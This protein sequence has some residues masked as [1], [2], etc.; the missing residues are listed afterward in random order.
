[1]PVSH[2]IRTT[3]VAGLLFVVG[4]PT[5][6]C[7][8]EDSP[9]E[10]QERR[11]TLAM[12]QEVIV[13]TSTVR[14]ELRGTDRLEADRAR[15]DIEGE[16]G[17]EE[18]SEN[19]RTELE[20][21]GQVGDLYV[22][23]SAASDLWPLLEPGDDAH[24]DGHI[25]VVFEDALNT[26]NRGRIEDVRWHF[27]RELEPT[28]EVDADEQLF[29]NAGIEVRGEGVLRPEEGE[30]QA[31]IDNGEI[32][33]DGGDT[34]EL[35]GQTLPVEWIGERDRGVLRL[36]PA[37]VGVHPG[38][39][40]LDFHFQ[41]HFADDT[42][43][44]S[45]GEPAR[46]EATL[47]KTF[48]A[49]LSPTRAGR[50][51]LVDIQGRGFVPRSSEDNYG[52]LLRFEG[53]LT[54][55][56]PDA[57]PIEFEGNSAAERPPYR[58]VDE[59]HLR[60]DVWYRVEDRQLEGV[61]AQP[62]TFSGEIT[63]V[64]YDERGEVEGIPWEGEF[65]VL[66]TRQVVYLKYLP[67]FTVA[68]DKYGLVNVERDI[69][70]RIREVAE[71][72]YEGVNVDFVHEPPE[73]FADYATIELGGPDPTGHEAFGIDNTYHD[74]PKDTGNLHL[75]SY[76]GG[77]NPE[78]GEELNTPYGGVFI[79][80]F[81]RFSPTLYPDESYASEN[82]DEVF[83]P[84]MPDLGGEKVRATEWPDGERSDQ[85]EEAIRVFG[86]VVGNTV[87]HELGH[88]MGLTHFE[89]DWEEPG[90]RYHNLEA[91]GHIMDAGQER[92]F[93]QRAQL[94]GEG[95]EVF[96]ETNRAYLETILP[97]E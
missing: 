68:L 67:A 49:D 35:D 40:E 92:S 31:V 54:P 89:E 26:I 23:L 37:V 7:T 36:D 50:G 12:D 71:R 88:S 9:E 62:G 79:E 15:V 76:I 75:D 58:V 78:T 34:R 28:F 41:N 8:D 66:P 18:V 85:I 3:L 82:F 63:P 56:D 25:E 10:E 14:V 74:Q 77:I 5:I 90:Q 84:F 29:A 6:S 33:V 60:Q 4:A 86:N 47:D 70:Q 83:G 73:N 87:S 17:G 43:L 55:D 11:L 42:T 69:R 22:D 61:G 39:L 38:Q 19:F 59:E 95:P 96:N 44:D 20:R 64:V 32:A 46:I 45:P 1:M 13:P 80:S 94:E 30:T 27:V 93:E 97:V 57:E 52:T 91:G 65:E 21:D 48:I 53:E 16:L 81:A 2:Q 72:D 51:Q 24:F